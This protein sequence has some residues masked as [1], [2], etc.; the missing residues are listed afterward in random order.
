M[1]QAELLYRIENESLSDA[2]HFTFSPPQEAAIELV[3]T[4]SGFKRLK[5]KAI[6][7]IKSSGIVGGVI[8]FHPF[9]VNKKKQLYISPHFHVIGYG[10]IEETK[11]FINSH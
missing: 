6:K 8:I 9:R 2:R 1:R 11:I 4:K 10:Y 3:K 7:L 5:S